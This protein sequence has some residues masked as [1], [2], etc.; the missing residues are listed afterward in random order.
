M[1]QA[2]RGDQ[3]DPFLHAAGL[4]FDHFNLRKFILKDI[5]DAALLELKSFVPQS[6]CPVLMTS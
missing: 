6:I 2:V 5:S 1:V 3:E 4:S